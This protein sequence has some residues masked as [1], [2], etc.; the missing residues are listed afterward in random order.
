MISHKTSV[1]QGIFFGDYEMAFV[2]YQDVANHMQLAC[3]Q[4]LDYQP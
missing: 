1:Q 3:F 2:H 4:Q